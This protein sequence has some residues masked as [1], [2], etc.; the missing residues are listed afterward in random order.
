MDQLFYVMAIMGCADGSTNCAEARIEPV[1]YQSIA[2]C[3]A[4]MG[5]ALERNTDLAFP[6]ISA[7]CR[8]SGPRLVQVKATRQGG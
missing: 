2:Q 4:A 3:Q 7:T 6:T 5:S 1:H 8:A